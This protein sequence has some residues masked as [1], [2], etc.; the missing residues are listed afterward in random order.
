[1]VVKPIPA[2]N[3]SVVNVLHHKHGNKQ[4]FTLTCTSI[5]NVMYTFGLIMYLD[6]GRKLVH[7]HWENMQTMLL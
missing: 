7:R 2:V 4:L 5:G 1:M 3:T 6:Y